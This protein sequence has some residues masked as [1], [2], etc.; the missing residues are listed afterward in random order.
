MEKFTCKFFKQVKKTLGSGHAS[1]KGQAI[2]L[3]FFA[4]CV[5][6]VIVSQRFYS[7][8]GFVVCDFAGNYLNF[9]YCPTV[10]FLYETAAPNMGHL[11]LSEEEMT[12]A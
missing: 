11:Q 6:M 12:K 4:H 7:L 1:Y 5:C 8:H 3:T 10:G 2:K 9:F